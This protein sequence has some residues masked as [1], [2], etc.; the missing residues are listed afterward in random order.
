[1]IT[2]SKALAQNCP[3]YKRI[4]VVGSL[5]L[6]QRMAADLELLADAD[7]A[8]AGEQEC[9]KCVMVCEPWRHV[10]QPC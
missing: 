8:A 2:I 1:M 5:A 9:I 7:G 3:G 10:V 6:L 4:G